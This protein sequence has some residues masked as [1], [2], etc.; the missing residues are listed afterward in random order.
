MSC[1][2]DPETIAFNEELAR[3]FRRRPAMLEHRETD[4]P[5][6]ASIPSQERILLGRKYRGSSR[7]LK[8]QK[9]LHEWG[10]IAGGLVH[11]EKAREMGYFSSPRR[12]RYTRE[13]LKE[14]DM[15]VSRRRKNPN[16]SRVFRIFVWPKGTPSQA[17]KTTAVGTSE[18]QVVEHYRRKGYEVAIAGSVKANPMVGAIDPGLETRRIASGTYSGQ[19]LQNPRHRR[20]N[21]SGDS[22][23]GGAI[24][25]LVV[26]GS[27][28][29]INVLMCKKQ[30]PQ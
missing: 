9:I 19:V 18:D 7:R 20:R 11:D 27:L 4:V 17:R 15:A 6:I 30:Q 3:Q 29:L 22:V 28:V 8:R 16:A 23:W 2:R 24:G 13:L 12:D 5:D 26:I 1:D 10:H 14:Y 21:P 25:G